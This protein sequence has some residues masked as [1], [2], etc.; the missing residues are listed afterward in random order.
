MTPTATACP[1]PLLPLE[2]GGLP[3]LGSVLPTGGVAGSRVVEADNSRRWVQGPD[4]ASALA[5][6]GVVGR[7]LDAGAEPVT[8]TGR[9]EAT[10]PRQRAAA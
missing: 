6:R 1:T 2:L 10:H 3:G 5:V 9:Q 4:G 7:A 8:I